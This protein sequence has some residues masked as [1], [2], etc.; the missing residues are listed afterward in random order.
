M[1][2]WKRPLFNKLV[3]A[4][5]CILYMGGSFMSADN[6]INQIIPLVILAL[7]L[8]VVVVAVIAS[9]YEISEFWTYR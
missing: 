5:I 9:I 7:L 2:Q 3:A 4:V 8:V 1:G 6:I